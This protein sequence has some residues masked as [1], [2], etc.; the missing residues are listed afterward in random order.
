MTE[1][2][3]NPDKVTD[4]GGGRTPATQPSSPDKDSK[5]TG[6]GGDKGGSSPN[7]PSQGG[8]QR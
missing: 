2:K 3:S 6:A 8:G 4:V 5:P 7:S 1:Q